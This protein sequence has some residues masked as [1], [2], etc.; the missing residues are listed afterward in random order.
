MM[1]AGVAGAMLALHAL[2]V[3]DDIALAA[4]HPRASS[5][6]ASTW[7]ANRLDVFGIGTDNAMYHKTWTG[8]HWSPFVS[9]WEGLV[10][11][12]A[13]FQVWLPGVRIGWISLAWVAII[14]CTIKPGTAPNGFLP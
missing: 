2:P 14:V 9:S 5:A 7:A 1:M 6:G 4:A 12:L 10:A 11:S 3:F 13:V 8:A